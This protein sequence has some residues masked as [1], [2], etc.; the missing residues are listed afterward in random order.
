[1]VTKGSSNNLTLLIL[2]S[3][4]EYGGLTIEQIASKVVCFGLDGVLVF[5]NVHMGVVTY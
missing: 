5:I 2:K 3:L 1:V 4:E